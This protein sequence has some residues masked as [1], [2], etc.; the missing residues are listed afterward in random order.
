MDTTKEFRT[1]FCLV[2]PDF[3]KMFAAHICAKDAC[4]GTSSGTRH[5]HLLPGCGERD[6][7]EA[8]RSP[9]D[10]DHLPTGMLVVKHAVPRDTNTQL[11]AKRGRGTPP[12]R[13]KQKTHP[14]TQT[15]AGK[16]AA[17]GIVP[18]SPPANTT[19][20]GLA[21]WV[22]HKRG[23]YKLVRPLLSL[24]R[25]QL[26]QLCCSLP[27]PV[28]PDRSNQSAMF[29]R[30]RIRKQILPSIKLLLNPQVERSLF[31]FAEWVAKD[32]LLL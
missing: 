26:T 20:T 32:R 24:S 11:K 5:M 15:G 30:N 22:C 25:D 1:P 8:N 9:R 2:S 4:F 10:V 14:T 7:A 28:Y 13:P 16:Q 17:P 27:L 29:S 3:F 19:Q 12:T 18:T 21:C 23:K 31:R 6:A